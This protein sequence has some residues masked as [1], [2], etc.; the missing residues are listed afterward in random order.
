[1]QTDGY[2]GTILEVDLT[3]RR[4][5]QLA[6][7]DY[8]EKFLGGRGLATKLYWDRVHPGVTAFEPENP[9]I[10][11]TGPLCGIPV[12]GGSRWEVCGKGPT[13]QFSYGNLGGRW[14]ASLKFAGYDAMVV[15]GEAQEPAFLYIHDDGVAIRDAS[16]LWGHGAIETREALKD[17]LGRSSRIVAIG[18]G[19]ENMAVTAT[20]L[21]ENDA[22]G[23][24]GL[25]AVM[26]AKRLKAIVVEGKAKGVKAA[27]PERLHRLVEDY[28]NL[29]RSFPFDGWEYLS[30]WSRDPT[31]EPRL[32]PG[33]EMKKDPC[34]GCL[35]RCARRVY[36]SSEGRTGK[37]I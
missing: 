8:T 35:G 33:P 16:H 2:A 9:L 10:L 5:S 17:E 13:G 11:A 25:G 20:L 24:G 7:R 27:D 21:A 14:G 12:I 1:M 37:F 32:M 23:S 3:S 28:R 31:A 34:Y 4:V 22:S 26:G 6:T 19:G 29:R 15:V 36:R 30:R 18:P